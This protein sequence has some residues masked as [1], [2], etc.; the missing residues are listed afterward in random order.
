L[1][2]ARA[3]V[4]YLRR[5]GGQAQFSEPLKLQTIAPDRLVDV[6][7]YVAANLHGDLC[8]EVLAEHAHLSVRQFSR[9]F[10]LAFDL[11]P[12]AFVEAARLDEAR[13][14]LLSKQLTIELVSAGVGFASAHAF[15]RA[16]QRSFGITPQA[17]RANFG[18]DEGGSELLSSSGRRPNLLHAA[19]SAALPLRVQPPLDV[20]RARAA[21]G[22]AVAPSNL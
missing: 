4:V 15:R 7:S 2:A 14:L 12:A 16:F 21:S 22:V 8:A 11:T 9:R 13:R 10:K 20:R 1:A 3:L 19:S 6:A 18:H 17:Y 5:P